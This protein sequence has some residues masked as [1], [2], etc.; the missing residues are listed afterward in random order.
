MQESKSKL[1]IRKMDMSDVPFVLHYETKAFDQH[2]EEKA[3]YEEIIENQV[4]EYY[5]G[6]IDKERIGYVG[7]WVPKPSAEIITMFVKEE[8]RNH[9]FGAELL[10]FVLN[11]LRKDSIESITLEVRPSNKP[12]IGLYEKFGFKEV[13]RRR[14]YYKDGEDALLMYLLIGGQK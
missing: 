14:K 2:L 12:A 11:R 1:S 7:V 6:L 9:Y 3:L 8:F 13:A 4:S 5:I 10:R